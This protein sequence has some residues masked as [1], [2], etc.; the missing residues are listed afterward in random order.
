MLRSKLATVDAAL[1]LMARRWRR[2][3]LNAGQKM[4]RLARYITALEE[5]VER[6][7]RRVT[8][9]LPSS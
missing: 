6:T 2:L 7:E 8:A 1:V 4:G 9:G 3:N 5:L